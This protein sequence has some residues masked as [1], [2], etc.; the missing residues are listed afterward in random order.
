M[1]SVIRLLDQ[2]GVDGE[3]ALE[4]VRAGPAAGTLVLAHRHRT[5][6]VNAPDRRVAAV[7][8]RVI[9]NLV[10]GDVRVDALCVPVDEG[11]DLPDAVAL[12][13]LDLLRVRARVGL[14]ASNAGDPRVVAGERALERLDL[15]DRA[16]AVDV[17]LPQPIRRVD[18]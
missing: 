9:R 1:C 18:R 3:A 5:R 12:G 10:H 4:L 15:A 7:V 16:A 13:P 17:L 8:Q 11:L 6:A 14:S 2:R